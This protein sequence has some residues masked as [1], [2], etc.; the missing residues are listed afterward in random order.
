[1]MIFFVFI[2]IVLILAVQRRVVQNS[3]NDI[4]ENYWPEEKVVN[5]E[6]RTDIIL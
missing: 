5:P 2:L 1:M 4:K 3:L 6:E